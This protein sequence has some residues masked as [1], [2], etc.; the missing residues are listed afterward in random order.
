M[1]GIVIAQGLVIFFRFIFTPALLLGTMGWAW[2]L[3]GE[4][5]ERVYA[6]WLGIFVAILA[7]VLNLLLHPQLVIVPDASASFSPD[8][9]SIARDVLLGV[10]IGVVAMAVTRYLDKTKAAA[11]IISAVAAASLIGIYYVFVGTDVRD[12]ILVGTLSFVIGTIA[13]RVFGPA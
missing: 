13:F 9:S 7:I 10:L 8:S 12:D 6:F 1:N 3:T 2:R 11:L 4:K 5:T